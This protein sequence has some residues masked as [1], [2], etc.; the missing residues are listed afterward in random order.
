M[1]QHSSHT[2]CHTFLVF[3]NE[4]KDNYLEEECYSPD[5]STKN[6]YQE[7]IVS[8]DSESTTTLSGP[9]ILDSHASRGIYPKLVTEPSEKVIFVFYWPTNFPSWFQILGCKN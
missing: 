7:S 5:V 4:G 3:E 6:S 8:Q 9:A 1:G 2:C